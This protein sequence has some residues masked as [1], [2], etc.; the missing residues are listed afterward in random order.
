MRSRKRSWIA[1]LDSVAC[2]DPGWNDRI[3]R[4]FRVR[5]SGWQVERRLPVIKVSS[6]VRPAA[7]SLTNRDR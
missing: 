5:N 6:S 3:Q 4:L 2:P 7:G 1:G